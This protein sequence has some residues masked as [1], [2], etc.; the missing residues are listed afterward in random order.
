M[1][2]SAIIPARIMAHPVT[3]IRTVDIT[4]VPTAYRAF[5]CTAHTD[6]M[7]GRPIGAHT[8]MVMTPIPTDI[9]KLI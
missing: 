5:H 9:A 1:L 8:R 3:A 2:I 6:H 7:A 4:G